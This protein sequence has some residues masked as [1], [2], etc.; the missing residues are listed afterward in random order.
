MDADEA[1]ARALQEVELDGAPHLVRQQQPQPGSV[2]AHKAALHGLIRNSLAQALSVEDAELQARA[3]ALLPLEQLR[4][5]SQ[6]AADLNA[7]LGEQQPAGSVLGRDDFLVQGLL[8]FF[9]RDFFTWVDQPACELCTCPTS[10]IG[11]VQPTAAEVHDGGGRV[12]AYTCSVCQQVRWL[13]GWAV[14]VSRRP[15]ARRA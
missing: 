1:L 3:R 9:K 8:A 14:C 6:E 12:E 4:L 11:M 7:L 15:A 5:E 13:A 10:G 2:D